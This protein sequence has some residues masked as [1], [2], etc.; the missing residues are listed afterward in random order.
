M[1][2]N[3]SIIEQLFSEWQSLQPLKNED[4]KRLDRKF[5][6][7]FNFNSNHIEGN[8]L[9]YGQTE[10]LL[11]FGR[12]VNNAN[13][14]DLE[15]MKASNVGLQMVKEEAKEKDHHLTEY[16]IRTLHKTLL[17]ED[18]DVTVSMPNG[19]Y[20]TYTVH[21]GTYKTRPNSVISRTGETFEYA[22][23]E[24]TP[25]LMADLVQWYNEAE[26]EKALSPI[27]LAALF[28]YRYIRIHPFED[29]NG[30]ISRLIVN[31]IL[32]RHGYPMIVV[33]SIDK[34]NYLQ[35]LNECDLATGP[36]PTDGARATIKQ[37]TPF[38]LYLSR[39]LEQSLKVCIKAAKGESIE[40]PTDFDKELSLIEQ[41]IRKDNNQ[42]E[43]YDLI[44]ERINVFNNFHR[45]LAV[46]LLDALKPV[47][48][49]FNEV[50]AGYFIS[51]FKDGIR[52]DG[53]FSVD[54][55]TPLIREELTEKKIKILSDA[56]SIL[57]HIDFAGV[58]SQYDMKDI[59]FILK[60]DVLLDLTSYSFDGYQYSYGTYPDMQIIEDYISKTKELVLSKIRKAIRQDI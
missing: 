11:L 16:F 38:V 36:I 15:E 26:S 5:M 25:S 29:G 47:H 39:C 18:Y 20:S 17:R 23:P 55:N 8:T 45:N 22:S 14:R 1:L 57:L 46:K 6:L 41:N 24:E 12:V 34:D 37:I 54:S 27:E 50:N 58:K 31:Y 48:R 19:S 28:H 42:S 51:K 7:E 43:N 21:A 2:L 49:F 44:Q 4:Q 3:M 35:A 32:Y 9:T 60:A 53:Y 10:F 33:K 56:Q 59:S 13:M 52:L 30:R 40:E